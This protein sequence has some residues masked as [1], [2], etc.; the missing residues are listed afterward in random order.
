MRTN[1]TDEHLERCMRISAT[2]IKADTEREQE[3]CK[4]SH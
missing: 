4:I 1:L 2:D 3:Q